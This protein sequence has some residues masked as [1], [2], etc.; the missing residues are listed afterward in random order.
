MSL[1]YVAVNW[2]RQKKL[3]DATVGLAIVALVALF[4]LATLLTH[5]H[6]TPE[7]GLIRGL[8]ITALVLLHVILCIGPLCRLDP[9]FLPL[10]YNRRHLGVAMCLTALA[11]AGFAVF[12]F[13]ALGDANPLL[14]LLASNRAL[15]SVAGFPFELLGLLA[16][17]IL[18]VMAATSHDFWL[19]VL[20]PPVWKALHMLV[21]VAYALLVAHVALGAMQAE[22]GAALPVVLAA[23]AVAVIG[24]HLA[25]GL[26]ERRADR[27]PGAGPSSGAWVEFCRVEEIPD[28]RAKVAVVAGERVAVFRYEGKLSGVSNVCRHQNGP[29]GEGKIVD[30]CITCPWHGYQYRPES[31]TSPPPFDDKVPTYNLRVEAGRVLVQAGPN[32]PGTF[33][34]P[35]M[36]PPDRLS[37]TPSVR[38]SASPPVRLSASPPDR[39]SARPPDFYIGYL[40]DA[41]PALARHTRRAVGTL[42]ILTGGATLAL[43][44]AQ[45]PFAASVFEY[46]HPRTM[47]GRLLAHPY[48]MLEVVENGGSAPRRY[49][50]AGVGKHGAGPQVAPYEGRR[51]SVLGT[52]I[53]RGNAAMLEVAAL[54]AADSAGPGIAGGEQTVLGSFTLTGEIVDSKCWTGVMNPGEGKTHL[55]CAVRCLS[56]GLTPL[57]V[58]R[59]AEGRERHLVLADAAGGP[60]PRTILP[61]VGRPVSVAGRVIR[62]G[63]LLFLHAEPAAIRVLQR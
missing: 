24:L 8:G 23:G 28:G 21:Y 59:D 41:P 5:P 45:A 58:V 26:R 4:Y 54:T 53:A 56:G 36:V 19:S 63:D 55:D 38:L 11:H 31:G 33:V 27:Q 30:G 6:M 48:P 52:V 1:R 46:G 35:V 32:P 18:I 22:P 3:Y 40:P 43:A 29:L 62:E 12:Q 44:L 15:G 25:A 50:L 10:L 17:V 51:V 20:T 13:H 57:L 42:A 16:L 47:T 49:L 60:M 34:E 37:A 14:S 2:N 39:P 61:A 9:R 7:T